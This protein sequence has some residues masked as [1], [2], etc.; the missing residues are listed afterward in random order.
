[1]IKYV[2]SR[3]LTIIF[4]S[5]RKNSKLV[6]YE[7]N[8]ST[9]TTL[10]WYW[11]FKLFTYNYSLNLI[12]LLNLLSVLLCRGGQWG[13]WD[14]LFYTESLSFYPMFSLIFCVINFNQSHLII[15]ST[16]QYTF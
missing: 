1:V 3:T 15:S 5:C 9:Q 6:L 16:P 10:W 13:P 11:N 2:S 8:V 12:L 14:D 4:I 7:I